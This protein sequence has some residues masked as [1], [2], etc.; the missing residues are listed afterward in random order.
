MYLILILSDIV[1]QPSDHL[2]KELQSAKDRDWYVFGLRTRGITGAAPQIIKNYSKYYE[3]SGTW[4]E[5][6]NAIHRYHPC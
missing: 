5:M 2:K 1:H 3:I 6:V 4:T